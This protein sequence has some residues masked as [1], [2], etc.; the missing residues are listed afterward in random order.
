MVFGKKS[1]IFDMLPNAYCSSQ[2]RIRE[3][4]IPRQRELSIKYLADSEACTNAQDV[5]PND[6]ALVDDQS[7]TPPRHPFR[8]VADGGASLW[9]D[10]VKPTS[11]RNVSGPHEELEHYQQHTPSAVQ[12]HLSRS[13]DD[14]TPAAS[15]FREE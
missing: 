4:T 9:L 12:Q 14:V 8:S 7:A 1:D 13:H 11:A 3:A 2:R 10:V 15:A 6:V 5:G